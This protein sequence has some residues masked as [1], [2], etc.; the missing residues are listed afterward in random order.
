MNNYID[1]LENKEFEKAY[2]YLKDN[3]SLIQATSEDGWNCIQLA[4]YYNAVN[5]IEYCLENMSADLINSS[6]NPLL[7]AI[8]E[9]NKQALETFLNTSNQEKIDWQVQD[10]NGENLVHLAMFYGLDE[11]IPSLVSKNIDCSQKNNQGISPVQL[12]IERGNQKLFDYFNDQIDMYE[13]YDEI[14]IKKSIQSDSVTI[15]ERLYPYS[16]ISIDDLFGLA[17]GFGSIKVLSSIVNDGKIILGSEQITSVIDLMCK[18]YEVEEDRKA[19]ENIA[20]YLF[21]I[22]VPFNK[23]VNSQGQTAWMLCIQNNNEEIFDRLMQTSENVNIIDSEGHSPLFYAIEKNNSNLVKMLLKKKANPN[24]LDKSKN[25]PLIKAVQKNNSEIVKEILQYMPLVNEV[26]TNNEHALSIAIKNRRIDIVSDLIWAGGEITTNPVKMIEEKQMFFF[27]ANGGTE[28][29][30]YY[31]EENIDNFVSLVKLGFKINQVNSDGD[32]FLLHFIKNGYIS[33]F[34]A[35]M[36]C[37]INPNQP[38]SNGNSP[39]MCAAAKRQN[40]YFNAMINKF[41]NI[42]Y[43]VKNIY[44]ENVYD[45]CFKAGK[46][47]R[48][49]KLLIADN[50]ITQEDLLKVA[51]IIAKDGNISSYASKLKNKDFDLKSL[52]DNDNNL[53]MFSLIGKNIDNFKYLVNEVGIDVNQKNKMG[54]S[55]KDMINLM[56]E[57]ISK[58]FKQALKTNHNNKP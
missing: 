5:S 43:G 27:G 50:N 25:T 24:Q 57:E 52:D 42:D 8:E 56:P 33:N 46:S 20:N 37:N 32:T 16:N 14:Y 35:L 4:S 2:L 9:K 7:I 51:K 22:N 6:R 41:S 11:F 40:E 47:D 10:K 3:K 29:N 44:G 19:A 58:E 30:S 18:K 21:E 54:H 55:I 49:E 23:F 17:V 26:N 36:R 12:S 1:Y 38:D 28:R 39:I 45:I 13:K 31:D 34:S 15:F 48:M 53:L